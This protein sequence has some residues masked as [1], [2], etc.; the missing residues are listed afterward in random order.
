MLLARVDPAYRGEMTRAVDAMGMGV[1][2]GSEDGG[3]EAQ[4]G[5]SREAKGKEVQGKETQ[6][7]ETQESGEDGDGMEEGPRFT[8]LFEKEV[9]EEK[10]RRRAEMEVSRH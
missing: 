1:L 6:G 4:G 9:K 3:E 5:S 10:A 7:K 2:V 8:R